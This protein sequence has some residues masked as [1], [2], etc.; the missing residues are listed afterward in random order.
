M[1]LT[2]ADLS[3]LQMP[4]LAAL[5][6]LAIGAASV[7]FS[8]DA[9]AQARRERL[10]AQSERDAAER[11]LKQARNEERQI[12]NDAAQ[13]AALQARGVV[14]EEN[15]LEWTELLREI[16]D[17]RRLPALD[18]EIAPQRPLAPGS[19]G[20]LVFL[21]SPIQL[22]AH[23][24]HEED[25][26]RLLDDLH[27]HARPLLRVRECTLERLPRG[28]AEGSSAHPRANLRAECQID[29]ITIGRPGPR[30]P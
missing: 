2:S 27:R 6:M 10:T 22:N 14:G 21:A 16:R 18:Y 12:Q 28:A 26:L 11:Q 4:L 13:F 30:R 25:L 29:W 5:A 9:D 23:L 19:N 24:L 20:D 15:R 17:R 8:R 3:R 1:K 7:H